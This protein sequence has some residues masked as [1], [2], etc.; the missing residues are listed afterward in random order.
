MDVARALWFV[1]PKRVEIKEEALPSLKGDQVITR[2]LYS[3]ISAG[4]EMLIYKGEV[5]ERMDLDVSIRTFS[6]KFPFPVKYGYCNVGKVVEA[7]HE[8]K[9]VREGDV[10]FALAPHQ[11][12]LVL[13]EDCCFRLPEGV[14]PEVGVF[15]ANL[16]TALG[17]VQ[18][19]S[20]VLGDVVVVIG[21]GVVGLLSLALFKA[22]GALVVGIDRVKNRIDAAKM[23]GA[24]HALRPDEDL[25]ECMADLTEDGCPDVIVEATGSPEGLQMALGIS[26]LETRIVVASWYG[27]KRCELDMGTKF[28]RNRVTIKSSQVSRIDPRLSGRWNKER[29]LRVASMFLRSLPLERLITHRIPFAKAYE[30]YQLLDKDLEG[31]LQVVL[32]YQ[33]NVK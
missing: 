25:R 16:E 27:K 32:D 14:K 20:P 23:L 1:A 6:G 22:S 31:V 11:T 26:G 10:V 7:G 9:S 2:T 30:A 24:D 29:R 19:S 18:D 8:C 28:H 4:T 13:D 12:V 5:P 3:G 21:L 15:M 33:V 17:I